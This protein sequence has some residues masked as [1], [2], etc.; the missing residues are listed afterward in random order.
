MALVI[1]SG[2]DIQLSRPLIHSH[3]VCGEISDWW[4]DPTLS[5][6]KMNNSCRINITITRTWKKEG[7]HCLT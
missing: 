4:L 1:L 6:L 5:G 7:V 3:A 2:S